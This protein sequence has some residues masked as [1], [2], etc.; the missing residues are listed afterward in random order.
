M[1]LHILR[2]MKTE[3][4]LVFAD[5]CTHEEY[6]KC[7]ITMLLLWFLPARCSDQVCCTLY[8]CCTFV[9]R[10]LWNQVVVK[11][12]SYVVEQF[13]IILLAEMCHL[14]LALSDADT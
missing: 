13:D 4:I 7:D 10:R 1:Q 6:M 2:G 8:T 9:I 11:Q 12:C 3:V 14:T 5:I